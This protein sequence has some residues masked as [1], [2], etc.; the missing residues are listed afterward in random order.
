MKRK[1]LEKAYTDVVS[2]EL[3]EWQQNG[4]LLN[5]LKNLEN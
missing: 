3:P 4:E 5:W 2:D 1:A